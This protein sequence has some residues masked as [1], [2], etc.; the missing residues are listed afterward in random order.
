MFGQIAVKCDKLNT[1]MKL[2]NYSPNVLFVLF[3]YLFS[4]VG[5]LLGQSVSDCDGAQVICTNSTLSFN[6]SGMGSVDDFSSPNNFSGCLAT[7]ENNSVWYYFEFDNNTLPGEIITFVIDANNAADYDFAVFG[8][9]ADCGSLGAPIR[10]SYAGGNGDTGL[11][12]GSFDNTEG[13]GGDGF[14]API[15]VG[16]GQ[17]FYLL[18]DNFSGN[19][20]SFT[21]TW[22]G[23]AAD[24]LNCNP[25]NIEVLSYT[26][27]W[28][29]CPGGPG[30]TFDIMLDGTSP[31]TLYEWSSPDGGMPYLSNG[32]ILNPT[33][34]IPPGV[35]GTFTYNLTIT[36]G[37]CTE[38]LT[39]TVTA[40]GVP[41]L[42]ITGDNEFCP[43]ESATLTVTPGNLPS[44][45]WSNGGTGPSITVSAG[46]TYT[47]TATNASNCTG[48]ASFTVTE[49]SAPTVDITGDLDI[50]DGESTT[51]TASPGFTG[52]DWSTGAATPS[53]TVANP[54]TYSVTATSSAGCDAI[55]S[56]QVTQVPAPTPVIDGPVSLCPGESGTLSV[57]NGPFSSYLW[58]DGNTGS[59]INING[60]GTY[61]VTVTNASGCTG[62]TS[63]TVSPADPPVPQITG[64]LVVCPG[65]PGTLQV[66]GNYQSYVWSTGETTPSIT[67]PGPGPYSVTVTNAAGCIGSNTVNVTESLVIPPIITGPFELCENVGGVLETTSDYSSY[68]W[69][70]GSNQSF[71]AIPGPG[72]YSLTV[73]NADGCTSSSTYL[74]GLAPPPVPVIIGNTPFCQGESI[75]LG[76]S[77]SYTNYAWSTGSTAPTVEVFATGPVSVTVTDANG[78]T[79]TA[80]VDVVASPLPVVEITGPTEVCLTTVAT[81]NATPG[82][83]SYTWSDGTVGAVHPAATPGL[84]SVTATDASGC[85]G[86]ATYT[87][88]PASQP[89]PTITG[90]L[91]FCEGSATTLTVTGGYTSVAWSNSEVGPATAVT[92]SG[93]YTATVTNAAGCTGTATAQVAALPLPAVDIDAPPG[94][95]L[96][97]TATLQATPGYPDYQWSDFSSTNSFTQVAAPGV[98]SVTATDA[99]GCQNT[100]SVMLEAFDPPLVTIDGPDAFCAGNSE[101]LVA[102][103]GPFDT[104]SWNTGAATD[105]LPLDEA[106]TYSVTVTDFNGCTGE[107]STTVAEGENPVPVLAG[108]LLL[109]NGGSTTLGTTEDF[110]A[111][112]WSNGSTQDTAVYLSAGVVSLT[113]T[114]ENGCTG[115][116]EDTLQITVLDTP[117]ISGPAQA[118][119]D[120]AV[121]LTAEGDYDTYQWSNGVDSN[122]TLVNGPGSYTLEVADSLGCTG[123]AELTVNAAPVPVI[124][125]Q[126]T[127][128]C[129]GDT[130]LLEGPDGFEAYFWQDSLMQEDLT[131]TQGGSYSL[132]VANAAGC[133]DTAVYTLTENSL[134]VLGISGEAAICEGEQSELT[135]SP[136]YPDYAWSTGE[137]TAG[138]SVDSSGSYGVTVT[139]ENGC[140]NTEAFDLQ[141]TALPDA[142]IDGILSFCDGG[143][144]VLRAQDGLSYEWSTGGTAQEI[145]VDQP[146]TYILTVENAAGC[147]ST[148][149]V[150]VEEVDELLPQIEGPEAF[151]EGQSIQIAGEAGYASYE[152]STGAATAA[153][154]VDSPGA[155]TLSVTDA[156]GCTGNVEVQ[157]AENPLPELQIDAVEGFCAG[158]EALLSAT[159]GY[160]G[161]DWNTTASGPEIAVSEAGDYSLTVTDANGCQNEASVSLAAYPLPQPQIE[162]ALQFCPEDN[163]TL[164]LNESYESYA[165]SNGST[166]AAIAIDEAGPFAVSVTDANGCIAADT[167]NA[168][169]WASPQPEIVGALTFCEGESTV[170]ESHTAFSA[171][172]WSTGGSAASETVSDAGS[173]A[174]TVVDSN[175]CTATEEVL[176]E[177]LLL[178]EVAIN[179]PDTYCAGDTVLLLATTGLEGYLWNT[180]DS[181]AQL[182]L[183]EPGSYQLTVTDA[184]GCQNTAV[185]ELEEIPLPAPAI[186]GDAQFCPGDATTLTADQNYAGYEWSE[187]SDTPSITTDIQDTLSLTVTD[188]WGCSGTA[189]I[190]LSAYDTSPPQIDAPAAFCPESNALLAAEPGFASYLWNT[191]ATQPSITVDNP[192]TYHLSVTDSN[193]CE[194]VDSVSVGLFEVEAPQVSGPAGFCAG[195]EASLQAN[196]G[197][198]AYDWSDGQSG[199]SITVDTGGVFRVS[200][201]DTNGCQSQSSIQVLQ[202]SLPD[203]TIGGSSSFCPGGFASLNAGG[204][205]AAYEWSDG[206]SAPS[207]QVDEE[208]IYGLTVTDENGC[209]NSSSISVSEQSELT[210]VIAGQPAFCPGGSTTLNAGDGFALYQWSDGTEEETLTVNT[211]GTYS[212]T[213]EDASGCSGTAAV[214]VQ[215]YPMPEVDIEGPTGFCIGESIVLSGV[216]DQISSY[217]WSTG[218]FEAQ[219][220]VG[221]AGDYTV[222]ATDVN[223]CVDSASVAIEAYPLPAVTI[224]GQDYFC[225]GSSTSLSVP[226]GFVAYDWN[227]GASTPV[228]TATQSGTYAVAVTDEN[229]CVGE[230]ALAVEEIALPIADAGEGTVITCIDSTVALGGP[231]TT[232][233]SQ[234][235]YNWEGPA[236][237]AGANSPNP[238]VTVPGTYTFTVTDTLHGCASLPDAVAVE[239]DTTLPTVVVELNDTLD[240]VTPTV[241]LDGSASDA[242]PDMDYAWYDSAQELLATN[243][244]TLEVQESGTY[245]LEVVNESSGCRQMD[246]AFVAENTALPGAEAGAPQRLDCAQTSVSLEGAPLAAFDNLQMEWTDTAGQ[247]LSNGSTLTVSEAGTFYFHVLNLA[248]GCVSADSVSVT[249]NITYPVADAGSAQSIDCLN[250]EVTLD[251]S[252]SSQGNAYSVAWAY[253]DTANVVNEGNYAYTAMEAGDYYIIVTNLDNH[254]VS[255]ASVEVVEQNAAPSALQFEATGPTCFGDTDG[256][257][258]LS[259]VEGGTPPYL[260]SFDGSAFSQETLFANLPAGGYTVVVQDMTGCEYEVAVEL[261]EG[262]DLWVDAGPDIEAKLGETVALSASVSVPDSAI[263]SLAWEGLD[264]LSCYDCLTPEL[265]PSATALYTITVVDENGCTASDAVRV[266]LNKERGIY[267]PSAFS[268]NGDGNNDRLFVQ[269][270]EEVA[271]VRFFEVY[272]RWGEAVFFVSNAPPNDPAY[273]W[274][275]SLD[276]ERM[277]SGVFAWQA[278][279]EF[280][281]G[282]RVV[283]KVEVLLLR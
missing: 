159:P 22:G 20:Q 25:C 96:G 249:E 215:E 196:S 108:E 200:V 272:S 101:M 247:T 240:C 263:A 276:G 250:P 68:S 120:E 126:D 32:F 233:G 265:L 88:N 224:G 256:S 251:G 107:A 52:Y 15:S 4:P 154:T 105:F 81:L 207:I 278:E 179:G 169:V 77:E 115:T 118:C 160:V 119:P 132:A 236:I 103:G 63:F 221:T 232:L 165:W 53:I 187:G 146:G 51:L 197:Y 50:C 125:G 102:A 12:T 275:G 164:S 61:S 128:F 202:Y 279:V 48:T 195:E 40:D 123:T 76:L 246:D 75:T 271:K 238:E 31:S 220:T 49:L 140:Q 8:P 129:T 248:N 121:L 254:C 133:Q 84:Y 7:E 47:V 91:T 162:G 23:G 131:A 255:T 13:A 163:S 168:E 274:D 223:G 127:A 185:F 234:L 138:I 9:G 104:Y 109:C 237:A 150:T 181:S 227:N 206:S 145:F 173:V 257:I 2:R 87:L 93:Q 190:A 74:V 253:Q 144:T 155:Y 180:Q 139:D 170:L 98:Y 16:P 46:G 18:I 99:S 136:G 262:N 268:P 30:V 57:A 110:A 62:S 69:I 201:T 235:E 241:K 106:G 193:G 243:T 198:V 66:A 192:G 100:A 45:S 148:D 24:N 194:T 35:N 113:V 222:I 58:S 158:E 283:F 157:I 208:G 178:P 261:E 214:E 44:Y 95:C 64:D 282:E 55:N 141:V 122:S 142:S 137:T 59:Q 134:P 111:Y 135:A 67:I 225:E 204:T 210:P 85:T 71:T 216:G 86:T 280:V 33:V 27:S 90:D 3:F 176:V 228:I 82:Y 273:G 114:D 264:S 1:I 230:A 152:W 270:G 83:D 183:S 79:G 17:G 191:N 149:S 174:L 188:E 151:C 167:V 205:Y 239:A 72:T 70:T 92:T 73:T 212:L 229:G 42:T 218:G 245:F 116:V 156:N 259:G 171:Y 172:S 258:L 166:A 281:D 199:A 226:D 14:V 112:E 60:A 209:T 260:Y 252:A 26:P 65:L 80:S 143:S 231:S 34:T 21:L 37:A 213:V 269:G 39:V 89:M 219:Q 266:F 38:Q 203:L 124:N 41:P 277:N 130:V 97:A 11:D 94:L 177:A 184:A 10:C 6:P 153:I 161:Y 175:G 242:G 54:G 36:E 29:V 5:A 56:V 28:Q 43:G 147:V 186:I 217:E 244:V 117:S 78:C 267:M 189:T 182:A 19:G 211:A